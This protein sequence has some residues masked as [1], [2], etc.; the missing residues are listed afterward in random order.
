VHQNAT[1]VSLTVCPSALSPL[2]S[3]LQRH[4][5]GFKKGWQQVIADAHLLR[6][7]FVRNLLFNKRVGGSSG[8]SCLAEAQLGTIAPAQVEWNRESTVIGPEAS[9]SN[10]RILAII[11]HQYIKGGGR[12]AGGSAAPI[13]GVS[14]R[15]DN[16]TYHS[17]DDGALHHRRSSRRRRRIHGSCPFGRRPFYSSSPRTNGRGWPLGAGRP[18]SSTSSW[19][20]IVGAA[21]YLFGFTHSTALF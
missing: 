16:R 7:K 12:A 11:N 21:R 18:T 10:I 3:S 5:S 13:N 20:H 4:P 15:L 14:G 2:L 17:F 8:L 1:F 9:T 6:A 19:F